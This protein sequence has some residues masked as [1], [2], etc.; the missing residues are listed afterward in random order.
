MPLFAGRT[1]IASLVLFVAGCAPGGGEVPEADSSGVAEA[2][3]PP[4]LVA[5]TADALREEVREL[6]ADVVV[7]NVWATWCG[8]CRAEFP[9][10]VRYDRETPD[11]EVAVRFLS[12]DEPQDLPRV[13]AF[14]ADHGVQG[15]TY[16]T[17]EG[18]E[19]VAD[20]AAPFPWAYGIPVTLLF[21]A[22]GQVRDYWEGAVNYDFL[23]A[24]VQQARQ[25][26]AALR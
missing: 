17:D 20:L 2:T 26:A 22:D 5:V 21:G 19:I 13:Q 7:L 8:P 24:K 12:V 6:D 18:T 11:E 14:L 1:L 9:E 15:R 16:L 3:A 23:Q 4:E 10:F 25:S